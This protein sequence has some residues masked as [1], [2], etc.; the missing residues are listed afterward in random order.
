MQ[1]QRLFVYK[2]EKKIQKDSLLG[3]KNQEQFTQ[4]VLF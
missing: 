1:I 2:M 3:G 4:T